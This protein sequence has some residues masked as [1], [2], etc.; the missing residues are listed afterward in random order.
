M[1]SSR[2]LGERLGRRRRR[3]RAPPP[4]KSGT[5]SQTHAAPSCCKRIRVRGGPKGQTQWPLTC[6][7]RRHR[8]EHTLRCLAG[9]PQL[10]ACCEDVQQRRRD[11]AHP[12][13]QDARDRAVPKLE[14]PAAQA[15]VAGI[16]YVQKVR[17]AQQKLGTGRAVE[18]PAPLLTAAALLC[19]LAW[20]A[21]CARGQP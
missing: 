2:A 5:P 20:C 19:S 11:L 18:A 8:H 15:R 16:E 12:E 10:A 21:P 13:H 1:P 14:A 4:G 17:A 7:E 9:V 6:K 3:S